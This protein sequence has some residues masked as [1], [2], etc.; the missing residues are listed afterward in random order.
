[1]NKTIYIFAVI[2][3]IFT[4]FSSCSDSLSSDLVQIE[5]QEAY[6]TRAAVAGFNATDYFW[7]HGRKIPLQRMDNRFHVV[8][9]LENMDKLKGGLTRTAEIYYPRL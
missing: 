9:A 8:F 4:A 1:M 2:F 3:L 7:F 6:G 5:L